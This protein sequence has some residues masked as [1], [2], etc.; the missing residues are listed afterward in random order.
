M[1][2]RVIIPVAGVGTRLRPHTHTAPKV[3]LQVAGKPMIGHIL[4]ELKQYPVEEITL[5][6]GHLGE[7]ICTYVKQAYDFKFKFITQEELKGL[8]HAIWMT[9]DLYRDLKDPLLVILGDTI[10]EADFKSII[11]S[12][13]N[14]IGVKEVEDPRRFGI[15]ELDNGRIRAM[16]EK[17]EHPTTNLAI[18]GIYYFTSGKLLY[19]CLDEIV[20]SGK[21]TKGEYQLTDAL[22]LMLDRGALMKPFMIDGWYDCGKPETLLS[23]NRILL[24]K[25]MARGEIA[26]SGEFGGSLLKQ[27]VSIGEGVTI[28]NSIVGP[29]VTVA[30][31]VTIRNSIIRNSI[32]SHEAQ[33]ENMLLDG[34]IIA[35]S[36]KACGH[37]YT[38]NVGDSSEIRLD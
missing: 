35:D 10:F 27:P 31:G 16:V 15:V 19:T 5:I 29:Y 25:R 11:G 6:V 8:G 21:T 22:Q 37:S 26:V 23:T 2:L 24:S 12:D 18:V 14:W 38:L 33:V 32:L 17:P 28:D 13:S 9:G 30:D 36:A 7:A 4:D 34:S 3:M 1:G 20:L